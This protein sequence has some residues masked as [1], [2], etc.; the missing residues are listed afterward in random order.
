MKILNACLN[1]LNKSHIEV[2]MKWMIFEFSLPLIKPLLSQISQIWNAFKGFLQLSRLTIHPIYT[3]F[4]P[5]SFGVV[6]PEVRN[7]GFNPEVEEKN[8]CGLHPE[9]TVCTETMVSHIQQVF[10]S[11]WLHF[12][13]PCCHCL[14]K[15]KE[16]VR[17]MVTISSGK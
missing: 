15:N 16:F 12:Q 6:H 1:I 2:R 4:H 13:T 3:Q 14:V 17:G 5:L 8:Y 9:I 11:P 10:S 7:C